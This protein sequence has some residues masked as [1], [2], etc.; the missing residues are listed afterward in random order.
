MKKKTKKK[1][2]I[3]FI[4]IILFLF[5]SMCIM[6]FFDNRYTDGIISDINKNT[7]IQNIEYVNKYDDSYIVVNNEYLY[8]LNNNYEEITKI[9]KTL[10]H[11]NKNNYDI[12]Y[13]DKTIMYMDSY[14]NKDGVIFEYYDIYKY[15]LIKR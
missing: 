15:E 5:V 7:D 2:I 8:L 3:L 9:E 6:I 12:V 10:L 13:R 1:I 11:K 4:S 14:K